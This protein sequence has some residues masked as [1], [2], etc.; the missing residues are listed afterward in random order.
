PQDRYNGDYLVVSVLHQGNQSNAFAFG[1]AQSLAATGQ[2]YHN[3]AILIKKDTPYRPAVD[4]KRIPLVLGT[5]TAKI[6]ST[7]GDYAYLDDQGRYRLKPLFDVASTNAGEASHPVRMMQPSAGANYGMHFPLHAGTEVIIACMNGD[8][9]RPV[10]LGAIA[11]PA[12]TSPVTSANASHLTVRT[13]AGNELTMDD[14]ADSEKIN[15][16]TKDQKNILSLDANSDGHKLALRTE[17]GLAEFYA[18]KTM[19]FESGDTHTL[20]T[21][22]DQ[23]ITVENKHSLQTN[24][25]DIAFDAATDIALT[26]KDNIKLSAEDKDISLTSGQDLIVEVG[27]DMS[28]RVMDGDNSI[29]VEQG[30]VSIDAANAITILAEG[31][32]LSIEQGGGK[33]EFNDGKLSIR[34]TTVAIE[35]SSVAVSG[36]MAEMMGGGGSGAK[37][38]SKAAPAA[39]A[40]TSTHD[41]ELEVIAVDDHF[42]KKSGIPYHK[43]DRSEFDDGIWAIFGDD[44]KQE[45][46]DQLWR[47]FQDGTF[48]QPKYEFVDTMPDKSF[49]YYR[50]GTIYLLESLIIQGKDSPEKRW[51]LFLVMA[52]EFGHHID[53]VHRNHY[54]SLGGDAPGDEGTF[55]A[56]DCVH[57]HELLDKDFAYATF[58]FAQKNVASSA[59][60]INYHVSTSEVSRSTRLQYILDIDEPDDDHGTVTLRNGQVVDVE[61]YTIRGAGAA[62]EQITKNAAKAVKLPYDNRLDEGC[63]WPD[64]PCADEDSVETSYTKAWREINK[65][66]TL[67]F[68]SHHGDLQYYHCMCPTGNPTNRQVLESIISKAGAWYD[69]GL[70][71]SS[72]SDFKGKGLF[73]LGKLCHMMQDSFSRSHTW[74]DEKTNQ[75]KTFQDYNKQDPKKHSTA[76]SY[77]SPGMT[78]AFNATKRLMNF[79][80]DRKPFKPEVERYLRE[81]VF[82]FQPGVI[83][84][85]AGGTRPEYA[86]D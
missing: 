81:E 27:N 14:L 74:R 46:I 64:V 63:A 49:G 41:I 34:G 8:P 4:R 73:H 32:P 86:K 30:S 71:F 5:L 31:G 67:A 45:M 60:S 68:R 59:K 53:H 75:V 17:E 39:V 77:E 7:G 22:N 76:D 48:P 21:G 84:L 66:G 35:G 43:R 19:N 23:T 44:I 85:P 16:H 40:A 2:T 65:E 83:D 61:F 42:W 11:N 3:E 12:T 72:G 54:S 80:K 52:E 78:D 70:A 37:A 24:K 62:H 20:I 15:L 28:V 51:Q 6:E 69:R 13:F 47:D 79:F 26:A 38:A 25:K 33:I 56:A 1:G 10:I 29:T 9:D 18:K 36:Q 50:D 58:E 82:P 55:F 57:F